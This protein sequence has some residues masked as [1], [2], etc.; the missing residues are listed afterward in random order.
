MNPYLQFSVLK[1]K[2]SLVYRFE[3]LTGILN[4]VL[5]FVVYYSIYRALYGTTSEVDGVTFPWSPPTF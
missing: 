4:S 5:S 3:Y 2:N 1:F